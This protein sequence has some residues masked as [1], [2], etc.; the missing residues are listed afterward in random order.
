MPQ[1]LQLEFPFELPPVVEEKQ[2][3]RASRSQSRKPRQ[4]LKPLR[5]GLPLYG[6]HLEIHQRT[7]WAEELRIQQYQ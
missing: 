4:Q 7:L 6:P 3:S 2:F 5:F 1:R